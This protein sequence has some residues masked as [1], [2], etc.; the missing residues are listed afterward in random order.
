MSR[1]LYRL[2]RFAAS[3]PWTTIGAWLVVAVLVIAASA[4]FGRDLE[5]SIAVPGLDSQK[6]VDLL[7]ATHSDRAGLTAQVVLTP[8]EARRAPFF[9]SADARR[10]LADV[11]AAVGALPER[12]AYQRSGLGALA[13]G[14][15]GRARERS[16]VARRLGSCSFASSTR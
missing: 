15:Q 11:Q 5:D 8:R 6:A 4:A 2:G 10:A 12:P 14:S 13:A 9:D 1:A 3:R 16:G 7:T